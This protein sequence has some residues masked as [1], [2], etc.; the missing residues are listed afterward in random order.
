MSQVHFFIAAFPASETLRGVLEIIGQTFWLLLVLVA[1]FV[2][3]TVLIHFLEHLIQ[4]RL[5]SRFGWRSVLWTGWL[6]TPIHELSHWVLCKV[7]RHRVLEMALFEPDKRSG[8][9]GFVRHSWNTGN[10]FE[11]VGNFFIG[12]APLIGGS[13]ALAGLLWFF[14]PDAVSNMITSAGFT[15]GVDAVEQTSFTGMIFASVK[16]LLADLLSPAHLVSWKFWLFTYLVLCV[17]GHMAPSRSD[18]DGASRGVTLVVLAVVGC[19]LM[20][21]L[22]GFETDDLVKAM[23]RFLSPIFAL[24]VIAIVIC[25]IATVVV[26]ILTAFFPERFTVT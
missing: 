1:P 5:A 25:A 24:L 3:F 20:I 10:W 21:S 15:Q 22:L 16:S 18:Y 14:Y 6:G 9:L 7:F 11:E 2:L 26:H 17:G 23:L 4:V 12:I 13:A 19:L 8:R